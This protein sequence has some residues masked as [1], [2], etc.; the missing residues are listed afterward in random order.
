VRRGRCRQWRRVWQQRAAR[1]KCAGGN[2]KALGRAG[3]RITIYCILPS[4]HNACIEAIDQRC[5]RSNLHCL[6]TLQPGAWKYFQRASFERDQAP[7]Q[8]VVLIS[9]RL[10]YASHT[11]PAHAVRRYE[12][13]DS[14]THAA[15]PRA[16]VAAA[17]LPPQPLSSILD[18]LQ[19][20]GFAFAG[21]R[22]AALP[23]SIARAYAATHTGGSGG[24]G[25][26]SQLSFEGRALLRE[27]LRGPCL[28]VAA[29]RDN[30]VAR[31]LAL[32]G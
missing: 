21:M 18:A 17:A 30:A 6:R 2:V 4:R 3:E 32:T 10:A 13:A 14:L 19:S 16:P 9:A 11:A 31:L 20:G 15:P 12:P 23:P 5:S 25:G 7:Q 26:S 1:D 24:G 8:L 22:L 27:L 29:E 28:A